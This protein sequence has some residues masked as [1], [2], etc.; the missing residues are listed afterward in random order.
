MFGGE[1]ELILSAVRPYT[2]G[3]SGGNDPL[4]AALEASAEE[5]ARVE[6]L[7]RAADRPAPRF[8]ETGVREEI[9]VPV[10]GAEIRV[11]HFASR[12]PA[13]RRPIVMVPGFGA[14]PEGFQDFYAAVRDKAELFYLET[15]EKS[16]SRVPRGRADMSVG[17]SARDI[18]QSLDFLGLAG[19]RDFVLVAPC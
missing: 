19:K 1:K 16:S 18:R 11:F 14:T 4:S 15:R 7:V 13:A 3:M 10:E 8:W 2:C 17:R 5:A 12:D 9:F 6:E